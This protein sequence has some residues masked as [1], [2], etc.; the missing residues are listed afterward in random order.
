MDR[1]SNIGQVA[2]ALEIALDG[3][4]DAEHRP[5]GGVSEPGRLNHVFPVRGAGGMA[6]AGLF[7]IKALALC[8]DIS[9]A[10]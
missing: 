7:R 5:S 9:D 4:Q 2:D 3:L 1:N 10:W 6:A 8:D